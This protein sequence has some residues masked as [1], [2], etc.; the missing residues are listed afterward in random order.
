MAPRNFNHIISCRRSWP[1]LSLFCLFLL[2]FSER[3]P[4][5]KDG[6]YEFFTHSD[7]S[8]MRCTLQ[9]DA[10]ILA[11]WP[12][13]SLTVCAAEMFHNGHQQLDMFVD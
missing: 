9:D 2:A 3:K 7:A 5:N 13:D 8:D 12:T 4:T 1:R 11:T 10:R 6:N